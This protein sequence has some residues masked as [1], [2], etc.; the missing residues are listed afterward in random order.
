[1]LAIT[2]SLSDALLTMEQGYKMEVFAAVK[3]HEVLPTADDI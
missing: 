2:T 3:W 1:M